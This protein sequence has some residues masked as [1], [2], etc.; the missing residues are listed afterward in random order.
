MVALFCC[1]MARVVCLKLSSC[2]LTVNEDL[3]V[4]GHVQQHIHRSIFVIFHLQAIPYAGDAVNFQD[5]SST[6]SAGRGQKSVCNACFRSGAG[7]SNE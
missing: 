2:N 1:D 4:M 3:S 6:A 5:T 7:S